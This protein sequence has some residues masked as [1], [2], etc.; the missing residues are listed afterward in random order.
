MENKKEIILGTGYKL[1]KNNTVVRCVSQNSELGQEIFKIQ[2]E[3]L[4]ELG[5]EKYCISCDNLT[6]TIYA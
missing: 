1:K 6:Y 5:I 4:M 2:G 3:G